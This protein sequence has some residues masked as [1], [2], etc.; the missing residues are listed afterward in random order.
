MFRRRAVLWNLSQMLLSL[1][2]FKLTVHVWSI[3]WLLLALYRVLASF[4]L[5][6]FIWLV[7]LFLFGARLNFTFQVFPLVFLEVL[8]CW[9]YCW[10]LQVAIFHSPQAT[11]V[12]LSRQVEAGCHMLGVVWPAGLPLALGSRCSLILQGL[13]LWT[14]LSVSTHVLL[15]DDLKINRVHT[16]CKCVDGGLYTY[17]VHNGTTEVMYA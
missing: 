9:G 12:Q 15:V 4:S 11:M 13:D 5:R 16:I 10:S 14:W 3:T 7:I 6:Q 17:V 2:C 8:H 1:V